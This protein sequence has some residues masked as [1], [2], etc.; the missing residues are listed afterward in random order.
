MN[1]YSFYKTVKS[2]FFNFNLL[3]FLGLGILFLAWQVPYYFIL[4]FE[5]Q[6]LYQ[7]FQDVLDEQDDRQNQLKRE[8]AQIS[9]RT[10]IKTRYQTITVKSNICVQS[11][12]LRSNFCFGKAL[13]S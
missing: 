6:Q 10:C 12:A 1:T 8:I 3:G 13:S 2:I 4:F 5:M 7:S 9:S 11:K